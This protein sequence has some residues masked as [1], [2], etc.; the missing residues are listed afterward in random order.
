MSNT[1]E[2]INNA[3][4]E[5]FMALQE[6]TAQ[7]KL[8]NINVTKYSEKIQANYMSYEIETVPV[9]IEYSAF[10]QYCK[11]MQI[12]NYA[13]YQTSKCKLRE[14]MQT[15]R[16]AY[17][18]IIRCHNYSNYIQETIITLTKLIEKYKAIISKNRNIK[19][20]INIALG[21]FNKSSINRK[22]KEK[23][24]ENCECGGEYE[25][26]MG[27]SENLC[28]SCGKLIYL[29][30][31]ISEEEQYIPEGSRGKHNGY[32]PIKHFKMWM[33]R[34]QAHQSKK[35]PQSVI[36][37]I[38]E[39]IKVNQL[40]SKKI[41]CEIIREYLKSGYIKKPGTPKSPDRYIRMTKYNDYV[42]YIRF[43]TTGILPDQLSDFEMRKIQAYFKQVIH[44]FEEVKSPEKTNC[45][46][47]PYFIYKIIEQVIHDKNR[48]RSILNCIHLQAS[49]TLIA[50]DKIWA[51]ICKHLNIFTYKPTNRSEYI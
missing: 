22:V 39:K 7:L 23:N 50:H 26:D 1:L 16:N 3:F 15:I 45:F 37:Y 49:D 29:K 10:C 42:P 43:I 14:K 2:G 44:V 51:K 24:I 28:K 11:Q 32:D 34:I 27:K 8:A 46:Y 30:G 38:L 36:I 47:H 12:N 40:V 13:E 41:T 17:Q 6:I 5:K 4:S 48:L 20:K 18:S 31:M 19:Q 35:I 9:M 25:T 21:L 33:S